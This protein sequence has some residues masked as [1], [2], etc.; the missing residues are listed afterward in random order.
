[1]GSYNV[2]VI[3]PSLN[4]DEKL[5]NTV[6]ELEENGFDD[7]IIVDDG[8]DKE[9]M[10]N[11]PNPEQHPSCT[12]IHHRRNRGKG[13]ALKS[14]FKYFLNFRSTGNFG[15]IT[16]DADGQHLTKDII[17]CT[18]KMLETG[19]IV[20]G[21]RDFSKPDVP[22]RSRFGNKTTRMVLRLFCGL[23]ITDTQTGLRAIPKKHLAEMLKIQGSRYEYETNM[24][25]EF[26]RQ[27]IPF[28]E[29]P[30]DTVY[31]NDNETSHFRPLVD[32][33]RI[34]K[35]MFKFLFSSVFSSVVELLLFY[36]GIKFFFSGN[37]HEILFA[38]AVARVCSSM[39]NFLVNRN[40]VF[41]KANNFW[42]SLLRYIVLAVPVLLTSAYSVKGLT[43]LLHIENEVLTTLLKLVVD[44]I[45]FILSF[46][47]QQNWVFAPV[48]KMN[49]DTNTKSKLRPAVVV[50]RVFGCIGSGLLYILITVIVLVS[51]IAN[52]PSPTLRDALV[53]SAKQASATKWIPGL[54]LSQ[55]EVDTIVENS[56]VDSKLTIDMDNYGGETVTDDEWSK[57]IDGIKYI[58]AS[59]N[60]FKAYIMLVRDPSKVYV[61]TSSDNFASAS[62]GMRIFA[63]AKKEDAVAMINGG[64]FA[65]AGG[66]GNGARPMG[67]TYSNGKCVWN[68]GAKR[69]FIGIDKNNKLVVSEGMTKQKADELN[70]RDAVSFQNGNVLI[71]SDETGVH[72]LYKEGNTG[73]AQRTA[74][75]QCADGTFV[76][77]VTDGRTASSI[78]ATYNDVIDIMV[79]YGVVNAAM[80]DGGSSAMMYYENYFDKYNVDKSTLDQ[81]QLQGLTNRYKAFTPPRR[82]PT[83]FCVAR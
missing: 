23:K 75:G 9:Y 14:A 79:S 76:F 8:S 40:T 19:Q 11:F 72:I 53:L 38:T 49:K 56:F 16:I 28:C 80:L 54:F 64:E 5:L 24:L 52:G 74:I 42:R 30:I 61:G 83:Y 21:Y 3:I 18:K 82:I 73:A 68:D 20:L 77:V 65:D 1:L 63:M 15:V 48:K 6:C 43:L 58:P 45:L 4:P 37:P 78:G 51:V 59:Y 47:I 62:E 57:A 33:F 12:I 66:V 22:L 67:L 81:Y 41:N 70:I 31:L 55:E 60:N 26:K 27:D 2:T 71:N 32:S 39:V 17:N 36:L 50:R 44:V 13:D 46:R 35:L 69:T 29:V 10:H 34:Y 25:L 7:I